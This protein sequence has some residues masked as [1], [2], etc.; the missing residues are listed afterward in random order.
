[1][2]IS[3]TK[4]TSG[5]Y[6]G[7]G[8]TTAFSYTFTVKDKTQVSVYETDTTGNTTLLT[9][10]VDYTVGNVGTDGGG[11]ITRLA[12]AL[13][14]DYTWYI[15][16]NYQQNQG[17][18]FRSQAGFHPRFHED[19]IDKLT[20]LVQQLQDEIDRS[21][22]IGL[23]EDV[24]IVSL[25]IPTVD[26]RA[27]KFLGFDSE[28]NVVTEIGKDYIDTQDTSVLNNA[29]DY[30]DQ[31][32]AEAIDGL[33]LELVAG[34]VQTARYAYVATAGQTIITVP[35]TSFNT[36]DVFINGSHQVP[37]KSYTVSGNTFTFTEPLEAGDEVYFLLG[38]GLEISEYS[39][40]DVETFTATEGQTVF[41]TTA[42]SLVAA[43]I[44]VF[45]QGVK[46]LGTAY[47]YAG[48]VLTFTAG[49]TEGDQVEV[50]AF[51]RVQQEVTEANP[52]LLMDQLITKNTTIPTGKNGLSVDPTV[53]TG[54]T[55]TVSN[56][57]TWAIV[58]D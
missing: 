55:V 54:V 26:T 13:P 30:T 11:T 25:T 15:R 46:Q 14:T 32:V 39:S 34:D 24:D 56:G 48:N 58:G 5:P 51:S 16:A 44:M 50:L 4:I 2:T 49:L 40:L 9:V 19:A 41:N 43:E 33:E 52:V 35:F 27:G 17:R 42:D 37:T 20:F 36:Q 31:R 47:S 45:I 1:M 57:S 23:F 22:K 38:L 8:V 10:D 29:N 3:T 6:T 7:N 28:G 12:G 53:D 21:V 18:A